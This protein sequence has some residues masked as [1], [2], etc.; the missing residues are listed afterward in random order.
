LFCGGN[1]GCTVAIK[2]T[3]LFEGEV[4]AGLAARF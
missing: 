2:G 1:S 4:L 3:A